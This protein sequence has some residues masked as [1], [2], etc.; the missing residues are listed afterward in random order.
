M[1]S[2]FDP[3]RKWLGIP[4][5]DQP[6]HHYRL[7]GIEPFEP[8]PDVIAIA[9]DGR[10]A[11]IKNFQ[12]GKY[13][14]ESQKILNEIAKAKVCLLNSKKKA[15]YD[16]ALRQRLET[17]K[18][19]AVPPPPKAGPRRSSGTAVTAGPEI[20]HIDSTSV[21]SRLSG[22][23][24]KGRPWLLPVAI[25][26]VVVLI[27]AGLAFLFSRDSSTNDENVAEQ[28]SV[29]E[30]PQARSDDRQNNAALPAE[31]KPEGPK[32]VEPNVPAPKPTPPQPRAASPEQP[33]SK[34]EPVEPGNVETTP[35]KDNK[36]APL[37]GDL[38]GATDET[39]PVAPGPS[40]PGPKA[41]SP[42][43]PQ[44]K[45]PPGKRKLPVP[46][47]TDQKKVEQ[48][49]RDIFE[50]EFDGAKTPDG[51]L[52]LAAKLYKQALAT[53]DVPTDRFVLMRMAC[54]TSAGAGELTNTFD[55]VD[56]MQRL[57]SVDPLAVKAHLLTRV[58]DSMRAGPRGTETGQEVVD[59]ALRLAESATDRDD[60]DVAGHFTK[61][62][63]S[64]A[65][66]AKNTQLER[67]LKMRDRKLD[68]L[69]LQFTSAKKALDVLK[70]T[71]DDPESNLAAG[72]WYC[73]TKSDWKK[74]IPYLAKGRD[75][76][77]AD[78]ARQEMDHPA[79]PNDRTKLADGWWDRAET[80]ESLAKPEIQSRAVFWYKQALPKLKGLDKVRIEKRLEE[81]TAA[82]KPSEPKLRG[83][84]QPGNVA[85]ARN[86]TAVTGVDKRAPVLL[87]GD[88]R[89]I[90]DREGFAY[91]DYPCEWTIILNKVYQL[92]EIRLKLWD[93]DNRFY[94]YAIATSP[95]GK[96]FIP[97]A[98]RSKGQ[99]RS[100][101][102][103]QFPVRSVKAIKLFGLY[104][105]APIPRF[106][107]IEFEAYCI[108]PKQPPR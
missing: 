41:P 58:V 60:F 77:L 56:R 29:T 91:G 6:P 85:L 89:T 36:P 82:A 74:G 98:D 5:Q 81:L 48:K 63:I 20:P 65:K 49:I 26:A 99:W 14:K 94:R 12:S 30:P 67:E 32:P 16:E 103:V 108:S 17:E 69:K 44:P 59:A 84:V 38:L 43:P 93:G 62:A 8:D 34:D 72:R 70:D 1:P 102:Q 88:T 53:D 42:E 22:H 47:R 87:D 4:P 54:E 25:G 68:R 90:S 24:S 100:W 101:Q 57:Y 64:A 7:L 40:G 86:G 13:S 31:P 92:R 27:A 15:K 80:E 45:S 11:Q 50:K 105:S 75:P 55:I 52:A 2:S 104:N 23:A 35:P 96:N 73:F 33:D 76:K 37:L 107:V 97:L 28:T 46:D 10:M 18:K 19:T 66:K 78:L 95:D 9:V 71:P 106:H 51:K 39:K 83:V 79:D 21:A 3:Y 61:L